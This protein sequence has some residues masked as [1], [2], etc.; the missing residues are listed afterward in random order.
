METGEG[1]KSRTRGYLK[2]FGVSVTLYEGKMLRL[3]EQV[4]PGRRLS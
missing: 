3:V 4:E 1:L 2:S